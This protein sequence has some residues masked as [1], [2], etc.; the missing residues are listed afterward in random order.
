L[1]ANN[2]ETN[3]T[4]HDSRV[5]ERALREIYLRGFRICVEHASPQVIMTS[6][7]KVNGVWAYYND[8]LA[9]TILRDEWD[10]DGVV[11][12]DWWTEPAQDPDFPDVSDSSYRLRAQVDVLMPGGINSADGPTATSDDAN[13]R[14]SLAAP[15]GLRLSELRRSAANVLRFALRSKAFR[16]AM[17]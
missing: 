16:D 11:I 1:A 9:T 5:S 2:Q 6:Y 13:I 17:S 10:F 8:D 7:N 14:R 12:T 3:R 4:T 15:D